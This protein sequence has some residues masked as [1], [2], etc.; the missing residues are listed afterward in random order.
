[1]K[2]VLIALFLFL[3]VTASTHAQQVHINSPE[4]GVWF[5]GSIDR[6]PIWL[7]FTSQYYENNSNKRMLSAYY[8]Y[9]SQ[10]GNSLHLDGYYDIAENR[11]V[12]HHKKQYTDEILET[13]E[14]Q[15]TDMFNESIIK[16]TW[17]NKTK[18]FSF[19]L[20]SAT[21]M[22]FSIGEIIAN[23]CTLGLPF[24]FTDKDFFVDELFKS[25]WQGKNYAAMQSSLSQYIGSINGLWEHK[26]YNGTVLGKVPLSTGGNLL[27][28]YFND[29]EKNENGED[30]E[31]ANVLG[32]AIFD[33]NNKLT[34]NH[35]LFAVSQGL[36]W[37]YVGYDITVTAT[38][39]T[40]KTTD[41]VMD[42]GRKEA[43]QQTKVIRIIN[44]RF[45]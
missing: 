35:A 27:I 40:I 32:V 42:M 5:A 41:Y 19:T 13:F 17:K 12:L 14:G 36:G 8:G 28:F 10:K 26:L 39:I 37:Q 15:I 43:G 7:Y 21:P 6:F 44:N 45:K 20:K 3:L 25:N 31:E 33:A 23:A 4:A 11:L 30:G 16:G 29:I 18:S 38:Q 2:K 9:N 34:D 1:M 22:N 24:K